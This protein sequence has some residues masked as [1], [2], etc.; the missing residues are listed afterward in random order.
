MIANTEVPEVCE[1]TASG[2]KY[3]SFIVPIAPATP[4][5]TPND[6]MDM[7]QIQAIMKQAFYVLEQHELGHVALACPPKHGVFLVLSLP[8]GVLC[9]E[10]DAK[11]LTN[12]IVSKA[13]WQH[14]GGYDQFSQEEAEAISSKTVHLNK[15]HVKMFKWD[16]LHKLGPDE[17]RAKA[18]LLI[19]EWE[20]APIIKQELP[21]FAGLP[22][23]QVDALS[24]DGRLLELLER[25]L[26]SGVTIHESEGCKHTCG[27]DEGIDAMC[28]CGAS[29]R[30]TC[31][32]CQTHHCHSCRAEYQTRECN[33]EAMD[34]LMLF[35]GS[36]VAIHSLADIENTQQGALADAASAK[37]ST[38][39][40]ASGST[41]EAKPEA[42]PCKDSS[43]DREDLYWLL[44]D[45]SPRPIF[46]PD[47]ES[48]A[49]VRFAEEIWADQ[50]ALDKRNSPGEE[51]QDYLDARARA[52]EETLPKYLG[53]AHPFNSGGV[54]SVAMKKYSVHQQ[55]DIMRLQLEE[56]SLN[57]GDGDQAQ[58]AF[59]TFLEIYVELFGSLQN[60][61]GATR[62]RNTLAAA[63]RL[64][65]S[66]VQ[67]HDPPF[68][69]PKMS[70]LE[71]SVWEQLERIITGDPAVTKCRVCAKKFESKL[72]EVTCSEKCKQNR[73][74]AS[75]GRVCHVCSR[76]SSKKHFYDTIRKSFWPAEYLNLSDDEIDTGFAN[77][78]ETRRFLLDTKQQKN[79]IMFCSQVC[80][81]NFFAKVVCVNCGGEEANTISFPNVD[82]LAALG[83]CRKKGDIAG[84]R[85]CLER[86]D[87]APWSMKDTCKSCG[88]HMALRGPMQH[89]PTVLA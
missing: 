74:S 2:Y 47:P 82:A 54:K 16:E 3:G 25:H 52:H 67:E 85:R 69:L 70:G 11:A 38:L 79:P 62:T 18:K 88:S 42:Q 23:A 30:F 14:E 65:E 15:H 59:P 78:P 34:E 50:Q 41:G 37:P 6:R 68:K 13:Y 24:R 73:Q 76:P 55:L 51:E 10:A 66:L 63:R 21:M 4:G 72:G 86:A 81:A 60:S 58:L 1:V 29:A 33:R 53:R 84:M 8:E 39:A 31:A 57:I 36:A 20:A 7:P 26:A 46:V 40:L 77:Q 56:Q 12:R 89:R 83:V 9:R 43:I 80:E 19:D 35:V 87:A 75:D 17:L 5:T 22:D 61:T 44:P 27:R 64:F 49:Q 71:P 32:A 48:P 28:A 45:P